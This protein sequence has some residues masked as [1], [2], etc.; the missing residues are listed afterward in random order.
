MNLKLVDALIQSGF[1]A[2][3]IHEFDLCMLHD[4]RMYYIGMEEK[5]HVQCSKCGMSDDIA[6]LMGLDPKYFN[7]REEFV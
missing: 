3:E 4:F 2:K 5:L 1:T 7:S 6:L